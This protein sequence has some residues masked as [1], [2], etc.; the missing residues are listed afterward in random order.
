MTKK[1]WFYYKIERT[2]GITWE[3]RGGDY[4]VCSCPLEEDA[5]AI[6]EAIENHAEIMSRNMCLESSIQA[7]R[8][9]N[10]LMRQACDDALTSVSQMVRRMNENRPTDL[11]IWD[12]LFYS[13]IGILIGVLAV[14]FIGGR[15]I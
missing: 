9:S 1:P 15:G 4:V 2:E 11:P 3:I 5:K 7:Y 6:C 10:D 8:F 14:N 12:K 13:A